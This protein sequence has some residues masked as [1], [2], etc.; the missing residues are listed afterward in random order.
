MSDRRRPVR[1]VAIG[2]AAVVVTACAPMTAP[3]AAP[4]HL[5]IAP[6]PV[7]TPAAEAEGATP[8]L[9]PL[10]DDARVLDPGWDVPPQKEGGT[11]LALAAESDRIVFSAVS[12]QGTVLWTA[13]RPVLCSAF[14]ASKGDGGRS[15]AILMNV[16]AGVTTFSDTSVSA[17]DLRT[18]EEVWGPVE[19]PGPHTG[20][21]LVFAA[22]PQASMGDSGPRIA[23][24]P[25]TGEVLADEA[26]HSDLTILGEGDGILLLADS[27]RLVARTVDERELWYEPSD[28]LGLPA[29]T[30]L[31]AA[32]LAIDGD[33]ALLGDPD[34]GAALIDLATGTVISDEARATMLD[35]HS[36]IRVILDDAL[37]GV[38][39]SGKPLWSHEAPGESTLVSVGHGDAYVAAPEGIR[40]LDT[41]TGAVRHVL[42]RDTV[43]P[44]QITAAGAGIVGTYDQPLIVTRSPEEQ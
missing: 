39:P 29:D 17:Y 35:E 26:E 12:G 30:P 18:G 34:T 25:A 4:A 22:P 13:E 5:D 6:R 23:L 21:G 24:D 19:V 8:S 31:S 15:L 42:P 43:V 37:H 40:V 32:A 11:Y 7:A 2:L 10:F 1:A 28:R 14:L 41:R 44:M 36:G 27:H 20:P 38:D 9:P 16:E 33:V 3:G